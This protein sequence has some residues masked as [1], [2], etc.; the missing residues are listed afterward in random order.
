MSVAAGRL[1]PAVLKMPEKAI[2]FGVSDGLGKRA[3]TWKC[4]TQTGSGK[5]DFYLTCRSVGGALKASLHQSGS[6]HIAFL[7]KFVKENVEK[8]LDSQFDPYIARWPRPG[9]TAPGLTLAFRIVVPW[10][11]VTVPIHDSLPAS[12]IWIRQ[13]PVGKAV[14][15]AILIAGKTTCSVDWPGRDSMKTELVGSLAL[16]NGDILWIVHH[17]VDVPNFG[18]FSGRRT[19]FKQG[20]GIP[21]AD[22]DLRVIL[23][24][25]SQDGS[26]F[27]VDAV[28]DGSANRSMKNGGN[29]QPPEQQSP[30]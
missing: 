21:P 11:S 24:G 7:R 23:F 30:I 13:P 2:R 12:M 15:I 17:V 6:W 22:P 26:A 3:A 28:F 16:D 4:W 18:S 8:P 20:A 5:H 25:Q 29:A 27:M 19:L 10:S 1:T 9:E 14:E